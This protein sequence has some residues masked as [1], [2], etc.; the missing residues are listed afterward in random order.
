MADFVTW[1]KIQ[2]HCVAVA[3]GGRPPY[4]LGD[5]EMLMAEDP[6]HAQHVEAVMMVRQ[7]LT[8]DWSPLDLSW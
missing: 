2:S 6:D 3:A 4:Q 8:H 7:V 1:Q 5:T